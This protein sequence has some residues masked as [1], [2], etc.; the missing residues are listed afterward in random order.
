MHNGEF[1]RILQLKFMVSFCPR[2]G[3]DARIMHVY[4]AKTLGIR[5]VVLCEV[6]A[7]LSPARFGVGQEGRLVGCGGVGS[8]A[9]WRGK[10]DGVGEQSSN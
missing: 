4:E 10:G 5:D 8:G 6:G 7:Y 3:A 9:R 2:A 1:C